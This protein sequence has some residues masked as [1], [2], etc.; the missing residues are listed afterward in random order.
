MICDDTRVF[1]RIRA[2]KGVGIGDADAG[3]WRDISTEEEHRYDHETLS[4]MQEDDALRPEL[5]QGLCTHSTGRA[6]GYKGAEPQEE[7]AKVQQQER[8]E[9]PNLL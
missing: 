1:D 8:S 5:L 7:D 6:R 9:V 4:S 3:G 2:E